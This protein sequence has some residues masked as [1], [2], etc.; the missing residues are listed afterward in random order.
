MNKNATAII[1]N[2]EIPGI[3][4]GNGPYS[5]G[6]Y[7]LPTS[8]LTGAATVYYPTDSKAVAPFSGLV[9]CPPYTGT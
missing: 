7:Q 1:R 8:V 3:Y 9:Y 6:M 2:D 5:Y 4:T